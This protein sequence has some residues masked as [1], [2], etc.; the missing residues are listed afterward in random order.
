MTNFY[1]WAGLWARWAVIW[2]LGVWLWIKGLFTAPVLP[3]TPTYNHLPA[4]YCSELPKSEIESNNEVLPATEPVCEPTGVSKGESPCGQLPEA[5]VPK[6]S[7]IVW[8]ETR[9]PEPPLN[10]VWQAE[11]PGNQEEAPEPPTAAETFVETVLEP[12]F[13]PIGES[14]IET[15]Q[16]VVEAVKE[17][18]YVVEAPT[19]DY[20]TPGLVIPTGPATRATLRSP[21]MYRSS[22]RSFR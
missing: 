16:A 13:A 3:S 21:C 7:K 6:E 11:R 22:V 8:E 15:V 20:V 2:A 18:A 10:A 12:V 5:E 17:V 4:H 19:H 1:R 9:P 14:V